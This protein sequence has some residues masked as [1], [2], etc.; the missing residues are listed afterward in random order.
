[1]GRQRTVDEIAAACLFLVSDDSG[2]ITGQTI[3]VHGATAY[4]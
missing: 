1:L 4:Q 3:R 2:F